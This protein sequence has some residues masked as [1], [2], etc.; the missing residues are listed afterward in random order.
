[1][2]GLLG[3]VS[4]M[5]EIQQVLSRYAFACDTR[6]WDL[7][8][9]CFLPDARVEYESLR[10]FPDG[11]AGLRDSTI[12]T[13]GLLRS[14]QHLIGNLHVHVDGDRAS[15]VSY[16]QATHVG[17]DGRSWVTGGRYDDELVRTET[18]WR[19]RARTFRRQWRVDPD[20]LAPE[21][22]AAARDAQSG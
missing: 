13:L 11:Y 8:D 19:I 15:A 18:G 9:S 10:A 6:D 14:T 12:R 22:Q 4:D 2:T 3:Q 17:D 21:V 20:G 16:V 1:M 7:L 5:L